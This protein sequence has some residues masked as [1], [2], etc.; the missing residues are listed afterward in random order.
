M[1]PPGEAVSL[2]SAGIL[3]RISSAIFVTEMLPLRFSVTS[4]YASSSDHGLDGNYGT[5]AG[6]G[7]LSDRARL[8]GLAG[9]DAR[10]GCAPPVP[11][12]D[13]GRFG[14]RGGDHRAWAIRDKTTF[15]LR[16]L[17]H[18]LQ[19]DLML[20]VEECRPPRPASDTS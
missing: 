14:L 3:A 17:G 11:N 20:D 13:Q 10:C 9:V 12:P 7:G 18:R 1:G 5:G 19:R 15:D 4:R 6:R 8:R 16:A 2:V